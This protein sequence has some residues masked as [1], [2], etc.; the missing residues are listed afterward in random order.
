[1]IT[2]YRYAKRVFTNAALAL[3]L[4]SGVAPAAQDAA[5]PAPTPEPVEVDVVAHRPQGV[6]RAE[7]ALRR[8][9]TANSKGG[10]KAV[11]PEGETIYLAAD[12]IVTEQD[13]TEAHVTLEPDLVH[14]AITLY[15]NQ[16]AAARLE[17]ATTL[18][19]VTSGMKLAI[20]V[21]GQ[22]LSAATVESPLRDSAMFAGHY[23]HAAATRL[24]E[25]L[26]P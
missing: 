9:V 15:F 2:D 23:T 26:A 3:L 24:A 10:R 14:Y 12:A 7:L 25:K 6:D 19:Q 16:D 13:V 4:V 22:V 18:S 21:D 8:V 17:R 20:L 11:T 5:L 1:M